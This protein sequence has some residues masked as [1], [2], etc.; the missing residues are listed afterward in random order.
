[1]SVPLFVPFFFKLHLFLSLSA[2]SVFSCVFLILTL[3]TAL[4]L[5]LSFPISLFLNP[6]LAVSISYFQGRRPWG[7]GDVPPKFEVHMGDGPCIR[8]PNILRSSVVGC[9]QKYEQSK[10]GVFVER[11]G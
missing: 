10:K 8:P 7:M 5:S 2:I 11:K 1:M 9:A 6:F 3:P 4:S